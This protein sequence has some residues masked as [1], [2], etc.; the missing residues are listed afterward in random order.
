MIPSI[1]TNITNFSD[2]KFILNNEQVDIWYFPLTMSIPAAFLNYDEKKRAQSFYLIKHQ[3]RFIVTRTMLRLIIAKYLNIKHNQIDF[4][5]NKYGKPYINN[6]PQL[7][8]N[9]SHSE[10]LAM[11]AIGRHYELGI[12]LETLSTRHFLGIAKKMFSNHE[13]EELQKQPQDLQQLA[14]FNIWVQKEAYIKACGIGLSYP[15]KTF[16][17]PVMPN[18]DTQVIDTITQQ[19]WRILSFIPQD[20][21]CAAI[22][23]NPEINQVK[24][25]KIQQLETIIDI[26]L[27]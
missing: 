26:F 9:V 24:Y 12:D 16:T 5:Y 22:C 6:Y 27:G 21:V 13:G 7:T 15:T 17:V 11:I 4:A 14:F 19:N 23:V 25:F 1:F 8:F 18:T 10:N 3:R 20:N 2:Y